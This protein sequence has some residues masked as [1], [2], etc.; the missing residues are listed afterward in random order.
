MSINLKLFK[1]SSL[2]TF[3]FVVGFSHSTSAKGFDVSGKVVYVDDGDTVVLLSDENSKRRI[4]LAN[5]DAPEVSHTK[6]EVGRIGQPF[7]ANSSK[8]LGDMVK[9]KTVQSH[10]FEVDR[11]GRDVCEIFLNGVSVNRELVTHG[12]AWANVSANGRYLHDHGLVALESSARHA[13][14]GLWVDSN[15]VAPWQWRNDCWKK[16]VCLKN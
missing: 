4:R 10:C 8:F 15:P 16:N 5:I 11:Y 14:L 12:W 7:S 6:K 3:L 1:K 9:G 13:R 2:L